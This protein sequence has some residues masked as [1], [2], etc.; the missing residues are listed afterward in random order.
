MGDP[1]RE[2]LRSRKASEGWNIIY[3]FILVLLLTNYT[4]LTAQQILSLKDTIRCIVTMLTDDGEDPGGPSLLA[5]LG[6]EE[7]AAEVGAGQAAL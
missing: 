3:H 6:A 1:I 4:R 5:E 2:Y 7:A